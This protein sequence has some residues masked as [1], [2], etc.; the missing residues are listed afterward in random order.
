MNGVSG[1]SGVCLCGFSAMYQASRFEYLVLASPERAG[2][3]ATPTD[4]A[5]PAGI[6]ANNV[7]TFKTDHLLGA[8]QPLVWAQALPISSCALKSNRIFKSIHG[9]RSFCAPHFAL[10]CGRQLSQKSKSIPST[11]IFLVKAGPVGVDSAQIGHNTRGQRG[12]PRM[13]M[14]PTTMCTF[15]NATVELGE[16]NE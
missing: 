1:A 8:D 13:G 7:Q 11:L 9:Y 2:G 10:K 5:A 14:S 15:D 3:C 4:F 12:S 6:Q 16:G